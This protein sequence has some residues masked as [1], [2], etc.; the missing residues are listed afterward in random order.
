MKSCIFKNLNISLT[1]DINSALN[2]NSAEV[3]DEKAEFLIKINAKTAINF[4]EKINLTEE[5][6]RAD[7][8]TVSII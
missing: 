8:N 2:I 5:L 1:S 3:S 4:K 7:N 6:T